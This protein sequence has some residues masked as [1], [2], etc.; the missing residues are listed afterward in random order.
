MST[1]SVDPESAAAVASAIERLAEQLWQSSRTVAGGSFGPGVLGAL[2]GFGLQSTVIVAQSEVL[3]AR[4]IEHAVRVRSDSDTARSWAEQLLSSQVLPT[5]GSAWPSI[6][7]RD[8]VLAG[9]SLTHEL[10]SGA[11]WWGR[12]LRTPVGNLA[13]KASRWK[14]GGYA[15]AAL[16]GGVSAGLGLIGGFVPGPAGT[17]LQSLGNLGGAMLTFTLSELHPERLPHVFKAGLVNDAG[18]LTIKAG[19]KVASRVLLPLAVLSAGNDIYNLF[20]KDHQEALVGDSEHHSDWTRAIIYGAK[21]ANATGEALLLA[22][23]LIPVP[24]VDVAVAGAGAIILGT[25]ALVR[26][27]IALSDMTQQSA[28]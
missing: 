22:G 20:G 9:T 18:A 19:S 13:A 27:G 15:D 11:K 3:A 6:F 2:A 23:M 10:Y 7:T 28:K 5:A 25:G 16:T 8:H 14:F 17:G 24:G 12:V 21:A 1:I 26:G 4:I